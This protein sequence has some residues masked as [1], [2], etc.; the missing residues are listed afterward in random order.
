MP[1][2]LYS[3]FDAQ[4]HGIDGANRVSSQLIADGKRHK[5]PTASVAFFDSHVELTD[6]A[7]AAI[8]TDQ[9]KALHWWTTFRS[10]I[11]QGEL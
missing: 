10:G 5:Y 9:E 1:S 2:K 3:A 6:M 8:A 11:K 4:S 7:L